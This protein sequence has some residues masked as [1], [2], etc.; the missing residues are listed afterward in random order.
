[1]FVALIESVSAATARA[2]TIDEAMQACVEYV[3]RWTGWP[4][5]HVYLAGKGEHDTLKPSSIW[6]LGHPT[7]FEPF[8]ADTA[9]T[10]LPAGIGL[11]G[12]VAATGR[13]AWIVDVTCDPNFP[14]AESAAG[15][16]LRGAFSFPIPIGEKTFA[17]VECFSLQVVTPDD[18]L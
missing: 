10:P 17:V 5:G 1:A 16:G 7:K 18:R 6:Y 8:R 3:C 13:P 14:R 15:C 11:P 12:R 2:E 4:V 9:R